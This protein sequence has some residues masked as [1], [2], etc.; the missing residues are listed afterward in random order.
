MNRRN[1]V[2]CMFLLGLFSETK[3][4]LL[5]CVSIS[6]LV[7]FALAPIVFIK[8]YSQMR[9]DG[10]ATFVPM[11]G[12]VFL[13]LLLSSWY[14]NTASVYIVKQF[15]VIYSVFCYFV[16]F[17]Y[18]L[19][20]KFCGLG[21][22]FAG[23]A[24]SLI[25]VIF[26]F[27]PQAQVSAAGFEYLGD[28]EAEAVVSGPIFW[29]TRV[30]AFAQI[31]IIGAYLRMPLA[32][33][34][35]VPVGFTLMAL[36]TTIS[37]RASSLT[38]LL[39]CLMMLIGGKTRHGMRRIGRHFIYFVLAG[40]AAIL[41]YK[42]V[43]SYSA[44]EGRLGE[45]ARIKY[46][47]QTRGGDSVLR[48]LIAGRAYFFCALRVVADH[49]ILGLGP[50]PL[51]THGYY[52]EFLLKYGDERDYEYYKATHRDWSA[53]HEVPSHSFILG[54]WIYYGIFGLIF[55]LR[56]LVLMYQHVRHYAAA[57]PQ[58][59]GYFALFIS[60]YLWD[61]FFSGFSDRGLFALFIVC[62]LLA[63]SVGQ[64]RMR[65]PIFKEGID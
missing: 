33:M 41:M 25:I 24:I 28:S 12:M 32:Y 35:S 43:Y 18:L 9:R 36:L 16:I 6:E 21:W 14:N 62:L 3:V 5:G 30:K 52:E 45:A 44:R 60:R 15:A 51:D 10:V 57:I 63:R 64:G 11:I 56:V 34:V 27:N 19:R 46:E 39:A 49:P 22:F 20:D 37:G 50:H 53:M 1:T 7:V 65:M 31:P 2:F 59:Y 26:A 48:L 38:F 47:L 42:A 4:F 29:T 23:Y 61:I 17:Y 8:T 55:F 54:G 40:V 58:W 13:G